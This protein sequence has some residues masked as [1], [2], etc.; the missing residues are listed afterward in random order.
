MAADRLPA[1]RALLVD[2]DQAFARFMTTLLASEREIEVVVV[3]RAEA[4]LEAA[5]REA[6]AVVVV[7]LVLGGRETGWQ[8]VAALRDD[9]TTASIPLILCSAAVR[10]VAD[11]RA[12]MERAGVQVVLKP[13]DL[14]DLLAAVDR[15]LGHR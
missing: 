8:V 7:D 1:R 14:D 3:A 4:A 15:S 5:R 9:P 10:A 13:F 12:E 11:R 6:P 2:D